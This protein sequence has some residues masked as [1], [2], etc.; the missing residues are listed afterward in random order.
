MSTGSTGSDREPSLGAC[1]ISHAL[2]RDEL[3]RSAL[4]GDRFEGMLESRQACEQQT[5]LLVDR[6][7]DEIPVGPG[8]QQ[9]LA[10]FRS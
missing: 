7:G 3:G 1:G 8:G 6:G 9:A 5:H 10:L 2:V 4:E